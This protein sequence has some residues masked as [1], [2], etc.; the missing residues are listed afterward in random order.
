[1]E[2]QTP[3]SASG[4]RRHHRST[5]GMPTWVKVFVVIAI[6][7]V[8]ALVVS[9][10]AGV[11]HGPGRHS[12]GQPVPAAGAPSNGHTPPEGVHE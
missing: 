5:G 7:V 3:R 4:L 1:M 11:K 10:L 6:V 2:E 12:A 8:L 9:A